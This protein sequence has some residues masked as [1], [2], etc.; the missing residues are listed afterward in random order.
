MLDPQ[1]AS[2]PN[3]HRAA[4]W[5][6][7][8]RF[9]G[10]RAEAD[11]DDELA[12]HIEMRAQDYLARGLSDADARQ[13][14]TRRLGDLASAR[15]ECIAITARR[16]RRMTRAQLIDAFVHDIRFAWRTLGRQKGWSIVAGLT[17]ALGIGA[18]TAV[19]SV[20]NTL[21]LHPL[22]YPNASRI[23]LVYLEPTTGNS[24]GIHVSINP[25]PE[26][27]RTWRETSKSFESLEAYS[28]SDQALRAVDGTQSTVRTG[29]VL[30]SFAAFTG[31]R[32]VLGRT[33]TQADLD[34]GGHV[35]TLSEP[36]WRSRFGADSSVIGRAI[37]LDREPYVVVGVMP[38]VYR[39][40]RLSEAVS[41][42]WSPLDLRGQRSLWAIGRLR[43][44]VTSAA[45][46]AELDAI[47]ARSESG[48]GEHA[49]FKT[50]LNAPSELV[51]FRQSLVL[52]SSAVALVLLI[53]CGNVAHLLL[54]RTAARQRELA[55]RAALGATR[56]RIVRQLLTES[57]LLSAAGCIGGIV[58]GWLGM[59]A[60]VAMRPDSLPELATARIDRTTLLVTAALSALTGL[61]VGA[62]GT[63]NAL[64]H[65]A[66]DALK[67][68]AVSL[69]QSRRQRRLR[70]LLV[71]SEMAVSTV[72]L[73]GATLLVRSIMH[74]Q[75]VDPGFEPKGLYSIQVELPR[76]R[77]PN[78]I[79]RG[80]FTT[81]LVD[82]IRNAPGVTSVSIAAGSPP[83]RSFMIGVLQVEGTPAPK[84]GTTGFVDYNAVDPSFFRTMGIKLLEGS[85][86]TDT[87]R[88]T[89][90]AMVNI[91][92]ARRHFPGGSALGRRFR[93]IYDGKESWSTI[94]GVVADAATG[95]LTS[96]A[97]TP[98]VYVSAAD[99]REPVLIVRATPGANPV[100][101][102]RALIN[103]ADPDLA[104]ATVSDIALALQRSVSGP[105][106]TM[107]LL[108]VFTGLALVLAAVGL[109]GV[110]AY[111]VAQQTREIGIRIALGATRSNIARSILLRGVAM[112]GAGAV[113]G[114]V[115][116]RWGS[117]LL[118][119]MLYGVQ[120][121]DTVSFA[122]GV[123]VLL[124][125]AL[126]AC[127]V[128][129]RR[130]VSVDP[131]ISIRAD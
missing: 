18:N 118:E 61:A 101:G 40:P 43:P 73:V 69:S 113:V 82:R 30:P 109:Y 10:P 122:I 128:P 2:T 76:A 48:K 107:L 24:T 35:V 97:S 66:H 123:F 42:I 92:F 105:R 58:I 29:Y 16:E 56:V 36:F 85:V 5:R 103:Q 21:L 96:E 86:I 45:A 23:A 104:P 108:V 33:F 79:A 100:A 13:A 15:S 38:A 62:L 81:Q 4:T 27:I 44:G 121:T 78:E 106:F 39:L 17:L 9:W 67:A 126:L 127:L 6:R 102:I 91:G 49:D 71:V 110:M 28:A 8:L 129:M 1:P 41:D 90:Q 130:A 57:V 20:V 125:T 53:A 64:R 12:F 50:R 70:S 32:P 114:A 119:H 80:A 7:Y 26:L 111:A 37:T 88:A 19:F 116:A 124:L 89:R 84:P 72:L 112:A 65:S 75:S 63:V 60:L 87:S 22:P 120:R 117:K 52:L 31:A 51:S 59:H 77:Y 99:L 54:A 68:G 25:Q 115:G 34:Q 94:V 55:I 98:L 95:G 14:A 131:L 47:Y 74:L 46:T 83:S 3:A 11:V 93:V